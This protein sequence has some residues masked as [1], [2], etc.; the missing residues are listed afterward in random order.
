MVRKQFPKLGK[1]RI[2]QPHVSP[3]VHIVLNSTQQNTPAAINLK[4]QAN[5]PKE[6]DIA[7]IEKVIP[8]RA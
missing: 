5:V 2:F 3:S 6:E 4:L 1:Y 8:L 7:P